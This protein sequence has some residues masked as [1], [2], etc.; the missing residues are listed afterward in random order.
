[1]NFTAIGVDIDGHL[2]AY[3]FSTMDEAHAFIN[4]VESNP[5]GEELAW[6]V[7]ASIPDTLENNLKHFLGE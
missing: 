1:M 7:H 3:N 2:Y 4:I 5:S 6:E